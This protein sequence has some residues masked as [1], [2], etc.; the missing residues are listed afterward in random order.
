MDINE[1][2]SNPC[3]NGGICKNFLN[4]FECVCPPGR[5]GTKCEDDIDECLSVPCSENGN[6]T[7]TVGSYTCSCFSGFVGE[8][9]DLQ[10]PCFPSP[11][12]NNG[13]CLPLD[14]KA[15]GTNYTCACAPGFKGTDCESDVDECAES[16]R[17]KLC[18]NGGSCVNKVG[19]FICECPLGFTGP[20]CEVMSETTIKFY[21]Y[22]ELMT[23]EN[24]EQTT[25]SSFDKNIIRINVTEL[26]TLDDSNKEAFGPKRSTKVSSSVELETPTTE[27]LRK[28]ESKH[29]SIYGPTTRVTKRK[30]AKTT[31][32][33]SKISEPAATTVVP[34]NTGLSINSTGLSSEGVNKNTRVNISEF[35]VNGEN[36]IVVEEAH[37]PVA[38]TTEKPK[39]DVVTDCLL[40]K[41]IGINKPDQK[42]EED[43]AKKE[44]CWLV[45]KSIPPPLAD[46]DATI[47][48]DKDE[49]FRWIVQTLENLTPLAPRPISVEKECQNFFR[50]SLMFLNEFSRYR[51][52]STDDKSTLNANCL[53]ILMKIK[54]KGRGYFKNK[55]NNPNVRYV[56]KFKSLP[57]SLASKMVLCKTSDNR[58]Y[59]TPTIK[60]TTNRRS[61]LLM[62]LEASTNASSSVKTPVK[63]F[64]VVLRNLNNTH[65]QKKFY[66]REGA[67][68]EENRNTNK[69]RLILTVF[70]SARKIYD[71]GSER[72]HQVYQETKILLHKTLRQL[73]S[74]WTTVHRISNM[75]YVP[76]VHSREIITKNWNA[77]WIKARD[78]FSAARAVVHRAYQQ[79]RENFHKVYDRLKNQASQLSTRYY[80]LYRDYYRDYTNQVSEA[81]D[82]F[83]N[84]YNKYTFYLTQYWKKYIKGEHNVNIVL[85]SHK[86][87][88]P[89]AG[90]VSRRKRAIVKN[91]S[92]NLT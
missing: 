1:C 7:N 32:S 44:I 77:A 19:S 5:A 63:T 55:P 13:R 20:L 65:I 68:S 45:Y 74:L 10:D 4:N 51:G 80:R 61:T 72:A 92:V 62:K 73:S 50:E 60:T 56:R 3:Q 34:Y 69:P 70:R 28:E 42:P 24:S 67:D 88:N 15:T 79:A 46:L 29:S 14:T 48:N 52:V 38:L 53:Q 39:R 11:C 36:F 21:P 57:R 89:F 91:K 58:I 35:F 40:I 37:V 22:T 31:T 78:A 54:R 16:H 59:T 8:H 9:C 90:S 41:I 85:P 25:K 12:K 27:T 17:R 86:K 81:A 49:A 83:V 23:T 18:S 84:T 87:R 30:K 2:E 43:G 6:C 26:T 64:K 75:A 47:T 33:S 76:V 71:A 66:Y 82:N